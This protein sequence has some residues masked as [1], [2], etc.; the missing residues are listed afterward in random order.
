[1]SDPNQLAVPDAPPTGD[2]ASGPD[3]PE[4]RKEENGDFAQMLEQYE[5]EAVAAGPKTGERRTGTVIGI[6][7]TSVLVDIGAKAEGAI[8]LEQVRDDGGQLEVHPGDAVDVYVEG[9]ETDGTI[10]LSRVNLERPRSLEDLRLAFER[11][12]VVRGKVVGL[13]KGGFVVDVGLK[14]FMPQSRSGVRDSSEM[15]RLVGQEIRCRIAGEPHRRKVILDRRSVLEEEQ[16]EAETA[17]IA[18][19]HE[20]DVVEGQV[21]TLATYGAF[22]D[23]G[24]VDALLHV[25]DLSW[26][27]VPEAARMLKLGDTVS[28]RILKIEPERHR[29]S[30]GMKQLTRDPWQGIEERFQT[31]RRVNGTVRRTTD[32]GAF[33]ELEPGVEGLI[34]IS[35]M[36]W[37][38]RIHKASDVVS[39]GETVEV[40]VL[41]VNPAERRI[42]L[43]LKQAL[44]DPWAD[45]D[46]RFKPGT[47]I[48][49][50]V[51]NLQPFGAFVEL[52]EGVDGM[53]HVGDLSDQRLNHPSEAVKVGDTVKAV[54]LDVDREKRRIRLGVKQLKPTPTD[55]FIQAHEVGQ[56]VTG[57]VVKAYPARIELGENIEALCPA[58]GPPPKRIEEGTLAAKLAAVWKPAQQ[59]P[60]SAQPAAPHLKSGEVRKFT[61][62][63]LDPEQ[64]L[65]EV[66]VA[67]Q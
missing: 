1:M 47:V 55:E 11:N 65:I 14:A 53:I 41:G 24:G 18:R 36:S 38:R 44:G 50:R 16:R 37:S 59:A 22:V 3:A 2:A 45:V 66:A 20:G 32:F 31:G 26:S 6:G 28:V 62:T 61:I 27:H 4:A 5:S 19:L 56:T 48:D 30:V 40:V 15:H 12:L 46:T 43:G 29:I 9:H 39:A 54:V 8:P 25:S 35:E 42:S 23:L 63:R 51:R 67:S 7:E 17:A 52:A 57:R 58:A 34:H 13:Q 10:R 33:V 49:A 60:E 21:K 64:K